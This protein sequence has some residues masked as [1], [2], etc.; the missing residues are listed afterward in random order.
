VRLGSEWERDSEGKKKRE[1]REGE[2]ETI[3]AA[4]FWF[5]SLELGRKLG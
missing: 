1:K 3:G 4:G 2:R 5:A